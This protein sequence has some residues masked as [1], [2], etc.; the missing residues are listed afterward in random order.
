MDTAPCDNCGKT[1]Y[2]TKY[3]RYSKDKHKFCCRD[4]YKEY[5][6]SADVKLNVTGR[7]DHLRKL[8]K[9]AEIY[10]ERKEEK[11]GEYGERR[12]ISSYK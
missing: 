2:L 10:K 11:G 4:C 1:F 7:N 5:R 6:R 12:D 8:K 3:Q 9:F